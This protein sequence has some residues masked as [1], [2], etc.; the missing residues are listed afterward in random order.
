MSNLLYTLAVILVVFLGNR[1]AFSAGGIIHVLLIYYNSTILLQCQEKNSYK[2][3]CIVMRK[4][5]WKKKLK[6]Y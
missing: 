1:F 5:I 3:N 4:I 2:I 6:R